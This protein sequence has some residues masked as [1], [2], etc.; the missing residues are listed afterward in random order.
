MRG[1]FIIA[2]GLVSLGTFF[3]QASPALA[4]KKI[5]CPRSCYCPFNKSAC[6]QLC[7][8]RYQVCKDMQSR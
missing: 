4:A 3:A 8:N 2:V 6:Q 5:Q 7:E 1:F